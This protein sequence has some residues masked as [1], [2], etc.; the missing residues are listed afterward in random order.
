VAI[1]I[2]FVIGTKG[3]LSISFKGLAIGL[4]SS[5]FAA[6]YAILVKV[7]ITGLEGNEFELLQYNTNLAILLLTPF[8]LFNREWNSLYKCYSPRYWAVQTVAGFGG[9]ILNLSIFWHI[10]YTSS[11]THNLVGTVK[12][13]VQTG[14][15]YFLFPEYEKFTAM[16]FLGFLIIAISSTVY[17]VLRNVEGI[18]REK[19]KPLGESVDVPENP[20][21]ENVEFALVPGDDPGMP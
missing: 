21:T 6:L 10:K 17:A 5:C 8:V 15:A 7:T 1:V 19:R 9:F 12:S 18:E 4:L 20:L 13:C 14:I 3:D 16:K 2:G 11:L